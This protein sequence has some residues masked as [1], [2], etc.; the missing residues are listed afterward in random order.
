MGQKIGEKTGRQISVN[1]KADKVDEKSK[2]GLLLLL[3]A[4]VA[5]E[6]LSGSKGQSDRAV[7][8]STYFLHSQYEYVHARCGV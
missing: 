7:I 1:L 5:L 8:N 3:F 6:G 4:P 2:G